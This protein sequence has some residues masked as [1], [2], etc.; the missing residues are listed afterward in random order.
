MIA[1]MTD[2]T[3]TQRIGPQEIADIF[4]AFYEHLYIGGLKLSFVELCIEPDR[5]AGTHATKQVESA[6]II[7]SQ[8]ITKLDG[9]FQETRV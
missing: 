7:R 9:I 6:K 4:A 3:G 1:C 2:S 8:W 5:S